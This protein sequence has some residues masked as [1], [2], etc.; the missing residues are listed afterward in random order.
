[1]KAAVITPYYKED[2]SILRR[3]HLSVLDQ[4]V[5]CRHFMVADGFPNEI[6]DG[7]DCEHIILSKS[8]G[9][10]GN[11][12]RAIGCLSAASQGF[13][14]IF[15][16]DADNWYCPDHV[17]EGIR[18]KQDNPS[19]DIG[20]LRRNIVLPD[21]TPVPD[22]PEDENNSH[23]DTTCYVF[24][25]SSFSML[26]LWGL[27]PT[28]L[29]PIGDRIIFAGAR[30]RGMNIAWPSKK[31]CYYTGNYRSFYLSAKRNPPAITNDCNL[32]RITSLIAEK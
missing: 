13:E 25:E 20:A 22:S 19:A 6:V 12:P 9:D 15:L 2:I 10:T 18:L 17:S 24:F 29:G 23:V 27:I 26:P 32:R 3:C 30:S 11:T 16:L 4:E 21:G 8:H 7:W 31:T 5:P 14:I 28:F 1:M